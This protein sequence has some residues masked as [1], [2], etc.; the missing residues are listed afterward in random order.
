[1]YNNLLF[2]CDKINNE[3]PIENNNTKIIN[4]HE[5]N[6]L[7]YYGTRRFSYKLLF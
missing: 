6:Q 7:S 3:I 2:L 1:M 4:R 5:K